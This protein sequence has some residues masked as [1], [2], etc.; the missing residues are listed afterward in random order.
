MF[1]LR[2]CIFKGFH[3]VTHINGRTIATYE[4]HNPSLQAVSIWCKSQVILPCTW[5]GM[6]PL[7]NLQQATGLYGQINQAPS[8]KKPQ[9]QEEPASDACVCMSIHRHN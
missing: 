6:S 5:R 3:D 7:M 4:P 8:S 1:S 2:V 9:L